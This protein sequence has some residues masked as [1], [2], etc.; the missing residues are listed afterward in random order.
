MVD[1]RP[2]AVTSGNDQTARIWDLATE[3]EMD[4]LVLPGKVGAL[5]LVENGPLIVGYGSEV[6]CFNRNGVHDGS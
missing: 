4:R 1:G 6:A 5:G 2:V 3:Q